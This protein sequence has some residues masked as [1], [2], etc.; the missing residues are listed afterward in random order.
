MC[1]YAITTTTTNK[2][3]KFLDNNIAS[4]SIKI[5]Y[6]FHIRFVISES[7]LLMRKA[8]IKT[9][10]T[11]FQDQDPLSIKSNALSWTWSNVTY[12]TDLN[13]IFYTWLLYAH[14]LSIFL[15]SAICSTIITSFVFFMTT[16]KMYSLYITKIFVKI[17]N[18]KLSKKI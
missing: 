13:N 15:T 7:M 6:L 16:T 4:T 9:R 3:L 17:R 1:R 12:V 5:G 8:A 18:V 10:V 11:Y 2:M 14:H